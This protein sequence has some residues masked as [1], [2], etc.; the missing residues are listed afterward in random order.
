MHAE[1][2]GKGTRN[3]MI[4]RI[5]DKEGA[6]LGTADM[7]CRPSQFEA[8]ARTWFE[9]E[10]SQRVQLALGGVNSSA[11]LRNGE[12]DVEARFRAVFS[13]DGKIQGVIGILL[14]AGADERA[15]AALAWRVEFEQLV[16]GLSTHFIRLPP[17]V[18]D[19]GI[20]HA[21]R[22][23]GEFCRVD[24]AYIFQLGSD[25]ASMSNTHEW[26]APDIEPQMENLQGIPLEAFPW[27]VDRIRRQEVIHVP[28]VA[29]LPP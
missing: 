11:E 4:A 25:G 17:Q 27:W 8:E 13:P 6:Y 24:R 14:N 3:A 10:S 28:R 29:D 22:A 21:L 19:G 2:L 1:R 15:R 23:I 16:T 18:I 9:R 7:N 5:W 12:V 20:D 26:C